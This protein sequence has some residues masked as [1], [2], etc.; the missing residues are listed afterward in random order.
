MAAGSADFDI[1]RLR[2]FIDRHFGE[3][4]E[5]RLER[6]GGGQPNPTSFLD[7]GDPPPGAAQAV[8]RQRER[9]VMDIARAAD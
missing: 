1:V 5:F 3:A 8:G 2:R 7:H 6:I 4:G 9:A